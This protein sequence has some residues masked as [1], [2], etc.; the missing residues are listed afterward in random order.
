[1]EISKRQPSV[2]NSVPQPQ[3]SQYDKVS[4]MSVIKLEL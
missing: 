2:S 4:V 3:L 1:M